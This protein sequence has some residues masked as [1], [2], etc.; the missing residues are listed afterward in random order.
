[1]REVFFP[2]VFRVRLREPVLFDVDLLTDFL[3]EDF[4]PGDFGAAFRL[5]PDFFFRAAAMLST[6]LG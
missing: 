3:V 1:L 6:R 2:G 4:L 5:L